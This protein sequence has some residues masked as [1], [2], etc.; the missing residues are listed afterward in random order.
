M[1]LTNRQVFSKYLNKIKEEKI[2]I[3]SS[4]VNELLLKVNG[5][6][7]FTQLVVNFDKEI[8]DEA[9]F[10]NYFNRVK[11]GEPFQYVINEANFV[12]LSLYVDRNVLIPRTETEGLVTILRSFIE[13]N[14]IN[15][16][17]IIDMCTGSG[18]IALYLKSIYKDSKIYASD[19]DINALEVAKKNAKNLKLDIEL[20][21]SDKLEK[22]INNNIKCDIFI[23]NPPY[24]KNKNDI[25]KQVLNY[26]PMHAVYLEDNNLF[27]DDCFKNYKKIMNDKFVMAFEI[28]FDQKEELTKLIGKYFTEDNTSFVFLKDIYGKDRYLI[29]EG[30][31][32]VNY[33]KM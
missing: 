13:E 24:V 2:D 11:N 19:I 5:F 9:L 20:L 4:V 27:Y 12:S 28:N 3:P 32:D 29:I 1:N 30:G 31:C 18:C 15:H 6:N 22:Y 17:T 25:E 7:N 14:N 8:K 23:S 26:E 21:E 33:I 16:N 10:E